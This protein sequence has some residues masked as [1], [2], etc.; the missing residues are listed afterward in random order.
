MRWPLSIAL[1]L[2]LQALGAQVIVTSVGNGDWNDPAT[3]DCGCVPSSGDTTVVVAHQVDLTQDIVLDIGQLVVQL[4]GSLNGS[5]GGGLSLSGEFFNY[6]AIDV[7]HLQ[8]G[9]NVITPDAA[10]FGVVHVGHRFVQARIGF[11]NLGMLTV[12]DTLISQ[13]GWSNTPVGTVDAGVLTGPGRLINQG[14]LQGNGHCAIPFLN[15]SLIMRSGPFTMSGFCESKGAILLD[16]AVDVV[17]TYVAPDTGYLQVTGTLLV[18]MGASFLVGTNVDV[19]GDVQ[20]DGTMQLLSDTMLFTM[21]ADLLVNGSLDGLGYVCVSDSTVNHGLIGGSID[22]CDITRT[23]AVAPYLD[24][25]D[26]TVDTTVTFCE[27]PYCMVDVVPERPVP[28]VLH[29]YPVPADGSCTIGPIRSGI[30]IE[31]HCADLLGRR[32]PVPWSQRG[33]LIELDLSGVPEGDLLVRTT[34]GIAHAIVH[35]IVVHP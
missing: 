21:G 31:V 25:N 29:A 27:N 23:A 10:N 34:S 8:L 1:C 5:G 24:L 33:P 12:P 35:L 2:V 15:D 3:W 30:P 6:G 13:A 16:G 18:R 32:I 9:P 19:S 20:V 26:G 4:S 7:D 17:G 22:L 14:V 28:R 11:V